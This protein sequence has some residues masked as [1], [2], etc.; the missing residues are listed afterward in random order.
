M[1]IWLRWTMV[2]AAG[3]FLGMG[4]AAVLGVIGFG[5]TLSTT[6]LDSPV[7][8]LIAMAAVVPAG[9]VGGTI[10]GVAQWMELRRR[11]GGINGLRWAFLTAT[12]VTVALWLGASLVAPIG[13]ASASSHAGTVASTTIS[14]IPGLSFVLV[15]A[16]GL[17]TGLL[18][19]VLQ[20]LEL[21]RSIRSIAWIWTTV[22]GWGLA[23]VLIVGLSSVAGADWLP[24]TIAGT[25]LGS[26]AIAGT[27]GIVVVKRTV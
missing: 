11:L 12:G 10:A 25:A 2:S 17:A 8:W 22:A 24:A 15:G 14:T 20:W 3:L 13:R 9:L 6:S 7:D 26:L 21:R 16:L 4:V 5:L 23:A 18:V 19:G 1:I 27:E